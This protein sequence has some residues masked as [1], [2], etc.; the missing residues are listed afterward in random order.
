MKEADKNKNKEWEVSTAKLRKAHGFTDVQTDHTK[1]HKN[2]HL[3]ES[4]AYDIL[5]LAQSTLL[6]NLRFLEPAF[7]KIIPSHDLDTLETAT[8]GQFLYYNSLH[9]CRQYKKAKEIPTRDYLHTVFHCLFRHLFV[10]KKV[11]NNLWNLSCDIAVEHMINSFGL[12]SLECER[13]TSQAWLIRELKEH[14]PKMTAEWIY[15]YFSEKNLSDEEIAR[16]EVNFHA[17]DHAIWHN[18]SFL[19]QGNGDPDE[20]EAG[21][22]DTDGDSKDS[23]PA[24]TEESAMPEEEEGEQAPGGEELLEALEGGNDD[25]IGRGGEENRNVDNQKTA[26]TPQEAE[27]VWKEIAERIQVDL[28]TSAESWGEGT[29]DMQQALKD[30][31]KEKYDYTSLLKR[32]AVLGEN[33]EINDEEF[34]YIFYTYG[35]KLYDKIPLVEPMEY[36]DVKKV[37]EFVIALDTSESVSGDMVQAF[38]TKTWNILKQSDNFFSRV[39][40]HIIQ[41]G[42][43]VEEDVRITTQDEFDEYIRHMV[44]KGFGGTDFRP[45]FEHVNMLIRQKEFTNLKGLIYFTDGYGTFPN[46]PPEYDA[47]FVFLDQG[48]DLPEVPVWAIKMVLSEDEIREF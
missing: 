25:G 12:R 29:G 14:L 48:Y 9:V 18:A 40:I 11:R 34:D 42:A 32:F 4:L 8:D 39:N 37:R 23:S 24:A 46:H 2:A 43:K 7:I 35:L 5:K 27:Q 41:C 26:L 17:D 3:A 10:G 33:I 20:N 36:K 16:L 44:L 22:L 21:E 28:D 13:Q 6:I 30:I 45:V 47:A 38:V 19:E 15:K 1:V 31:N